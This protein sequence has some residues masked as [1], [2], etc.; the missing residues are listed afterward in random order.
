LR[1]GELSGVG[2]SP[3]ISLAA[4][5]GF[6]GTLPRPGGWVETNHVITGGGGAERQGPADIAKTDNG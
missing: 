5:M 1:A 6:L 3:K 2:A 4:D